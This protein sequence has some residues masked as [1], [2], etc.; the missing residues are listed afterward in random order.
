M[1]DLLIKNGVYPDYNEGLMKESNIGI[2]NGKIAY[3]GLEEPSAV[4]IIDAADRV[5]S[6]GFIDIHMHEETS[7]EKVRNM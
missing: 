4:K 6:P 1:L 2:K 3:L 5:V 7:K